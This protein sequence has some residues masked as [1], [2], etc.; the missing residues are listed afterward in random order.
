MTY[1]KG[2]MGMFYLGC[3]FALANGTVFPIFAMFLSD[4][5]KTLS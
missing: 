2:S 3:I 4:M 1:N 5:I